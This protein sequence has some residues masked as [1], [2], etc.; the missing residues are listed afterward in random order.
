MSWWIVLT[1]ALGKS[2]DPEQNVAGRMR[3]GTQGPAQRFYQTMGFKRTGEHTF[4]LGENIQTDW[5]MNASVN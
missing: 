1:T 4:T 3:M 5:I 2:Q